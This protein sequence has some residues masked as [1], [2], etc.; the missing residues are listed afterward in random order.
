MAHGTV[1]CWLA[2]SPAAR[3][4]LVAMV[5]SSACPVPYVP[6]STSHPSL[7]HHPPWSAALDPLTHPTCQLTLPLSPLHRGA[8][9]RA[10]DATRGRTPLH[11]SAAS[12]AAG[13]ARL[14]LDA[15]ADVAALDRA[16]LTPFD[17][18]VEC[19]AE[20]VLALIRD[21]AAR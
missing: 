19:G 9:V 4:W 11:W 5:W 2:V 15:A 14:L 6:A 10:A 8:N 20:D 3:V 17:L 16:G 7:T 18:A 1:L 12:D 13:A 21:M